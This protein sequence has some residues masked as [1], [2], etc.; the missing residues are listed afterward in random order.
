MPI[1]ANPKELESQIKDLVGSSTHPYDIEAFPSNYAEFIEHEFI[2]CDGKI[3][4]STRG[5]DMEKVTESIVAPSYDVTFI[6]L[7]RSLYDQDAHVG[8]YDVM[9]KL[10]GSIQDK[11]ITIDNTLYRVHPPQGRFIAQE[12]NI[13]IWAIRAQIKHKLKR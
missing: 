4:L 5:W 7:F 13:F 10:I 1:I 12:D 11:T 2:N 6:L 3:L 8:G 9:N